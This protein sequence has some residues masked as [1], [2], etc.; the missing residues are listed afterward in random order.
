M[1]WDALGVALRDAGITLDD[2]DAISV[3]AQQHGLVALD[4]DDDVIRP[5]VLWND[6]RAAP[7]AEWLVQQLAGGGQAWADACGSRPVASFTISKLSWL[8]RSEPDA[9]SRIARVMLPHDWLT[10]RLTGEWTTDR[11]DASGTGYWSP[12]H[13]D[14]ALD[15]LAIVDKERDWTSALPRVC[16]PHEAIA[17]RAGDGVVAPGTGDNMAAALG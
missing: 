15:L 10:A 1:W 5:A 4:G 14:Y 3:A 13:D 8:H 7:D 2:A 6:T 11:G 9:W 17:R 12:E 16:G